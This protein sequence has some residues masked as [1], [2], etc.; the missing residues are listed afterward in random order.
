[1]TVLEIRIRRD[2]LAHENEGHF[3]VSR[4]KEGWHRL[5]SRK[6]ALHRERRQ[7]SS[8]RPAVEPMGQGQGKSWSQLSR[9]RPPRIDLRWMSQP[10]SRMARSKSKGQWLFHRPSRPVN[11]LALAV[12]SSPAQHALVKHEVAYWITSLILKRSQEAWVRCLTAG[13]TSS[14]TG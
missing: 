1:M 10:S 8:P 14:S 5:T 7:L 2:S 12:Q 4:A 11:S 13:L 3:E 6:T 9:A